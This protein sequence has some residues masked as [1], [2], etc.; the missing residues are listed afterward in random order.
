MARARNGGGQRPPRLKP[1][2]KREQIIEV[3]T[4][5]FGQTGY[6]DTKWADIAEAV[7]IGSTALYPTGQAA[8]PVEIM[9]GAVQDF[10][11]SSSG[12]QA[13]TGPR[14]SSRPRNCSLTEQQIPATA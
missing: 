11:S 14:R 3:A 8:L 5:Y 10:Q 4:E 12:S 7:G 13:M 2:V 6:E 9:V 1:G